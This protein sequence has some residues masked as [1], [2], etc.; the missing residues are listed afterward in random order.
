MAQWGSSTRR[1]AAL[2]RS[3]V[4][5][6]Q[7]ER[8]VRDI[9]V[10]LRRFAPSDEAGF[11]VLLGESRTPLWAEVPPSERAYQFAKVQNLRRAIRQLDH[12]VLPAGSLFSF[13][14][15]I[16]RASRSRGFVVGRM[17]Q[18]GCL[19]PAVGGGLCQLSNALYDVA[20]QAGCD[21]VERHAHS[22][23]V[24]GSAPGR[25]ATVAWNYVDLRFLSR[26][27][28]QL[29]ARI[30]RREL[31]VRLR[32]KR[33]VFDPLHD[34]RTAPPQISLGSPAEAI[35]PARSCA[36]CG[37][38]SCFRHEHHRGRAD[39]RTAYLVDENWPEFQGFVGREHSQRDVFGLPLDGARW[40]LARYNWNTQG[41]SRVGA[42][43]IQAVA[44]ALAVRRLPTQGAA[45]R[46][47]ELS[48]AERIAA[49]LSRL[50]TAD[51]TRVCVAQSLLPFLWRAGHL[52]ERELSV[53]M[54]RL[55]MAELQAR[56][57]RAWAAHPERDTLHDFRA[58]QWLIEAE[59][60][61]LDEAVRIVTP[62]HEVARLFASK[63]LRLDWRVPASAPLSHERQEPRLIAFPGPTIARKGAYE[64]R[65]AAR[66]LDLEIVCLG[67]ELEGAGFWA[68]VKTRKAAPEWLKGVAAV[69]Q[70]AIVEDRP[71][72]LLAALAAGV[73]VIAT[74][75]C[76]IPEHDLLTIVP[77][78]D[79]PALI[80]ALR[81]L[82]C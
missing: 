70:P 37:E 3:K 8:G 82:V 50:L 59:T 5:L 48:G 47:A 53:L 15:Q 72:H 56:L 75:A 64:V 65:D 9:G 58:P 18:G 81:T 32:G 28:L 45:R 6:H 24:P 44:R 76:G 11:V 10:G 36:T 4:V 22:R 13:W 31:V 7:V 49:S 34:D 51:V 17:L 52:A 27:T 71:R 42:A 33:N 23:I 20:L 30:Q 1:S 54:T 16:G 68:G 69:V 35:D 38:T 67:R 40:H 14:K 63:A 62:H 55:P 74:A 60:E 43:S 57:D 25:D 29:E 19:V 79:L 77:E 12:I 78:N 41:F 39:D 66:A 21:I 2:F 46:T 73:P 61:A 80:A 26:R